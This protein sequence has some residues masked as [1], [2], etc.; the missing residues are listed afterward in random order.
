MGVHKS[1]RDVFV[2]NNPALLTSGLTT[3]LAATQLGIFVINPT[4][5]NLATVTPNYGNGDRTI[6]LIQ[7]TPEL[8][9]NLH[10][11]VANQS[12]RSKP[13]KGEQIISFTGRKAARGQ[14][15]IITVGYDGVDSGKTISAR[16]EESKVLYVKLSGGPIDQLFHTEGKGYVRQFH[17][18]SGCC[19]DCGDDCANVSANSIADDLVQQLNNDAILSLGS[20]TGNKLFTASK[21]T[22]GAA[23]TADANCIQYTLSI[24]DEGDDSAL[25][26]VQSQYGG[27]T[28]TR[29]NR[30]GSNSLYEL[31]L[32]SEADAPEDFDD[33]GITIIS[34]CPSCPSGSTLVASG[35][36]YKVTRSDA[37]GSGALTTVKSD[38]G[39]ASSNE[40]GSRLIYQFGQSTYVLVSATAINSAIGTDGLEFLGETR[41][42]CVSTDSTTVAWF[43][44]QTLDKFN[45]TFTI[46]LHDSVCGTSRLAELSAAYPDLVVSEE[47]VGA[48]A[49]TYTTDV[50]S[51]CVVPGCA[52]GTPTWV[53]PQAFEGISWAEVPG[54]SSSDIS[55]GIQFETNYVDRITGECA[56]PYWSYDAEPLIIEVS[57]HSQDYNDTPTICAGEWPVTTIQ[58]TK[59]PV[60][61][62]SRVREEEKFFKG[63]D[64]KYWDD[65]P[66]VRE[67]QDSIYVADANKYYDQYT[68]EFKFNFHQSWFSEVLTDRY[69][70]EVYFPE[71][72]GKQFEAAINSYISNVKI[73]LDPVVL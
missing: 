26:R 47:T 42:S 29:I 57:Q 28:V 55:V 24:C 45:K 27:S 8:P 58:E 3:D 63:Y 2:T 25:G 32:D 69:R 61:V 11:A 50:L 73:G 48:C 14:N 34:D 70:L 68:L 16:C 40:S 64:R 31:V 66:I 59:L 17:A 41:N 22:T 7:G 6:Q 56:F 38:Y 52:P 4:K 18:W 36:A 72:T 21:I 39:I 35:F 12:D 49:R 9:S 19:D 53:A 43:V 60:G 13:I 44:G 65:N 23:P 46:T 37:G 20:R 5:D 15:Q 62:G 51:N 33:T 71:G 67:L 30:A 54:S 10:A 1:F